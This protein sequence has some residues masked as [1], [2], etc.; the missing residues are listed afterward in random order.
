MDDDGTTDPNGTW[1][2]VA[3]EVAA[4]ARCSISSDVYS[5]A[6]TTFFA[7]SGEYPVSTKLEIVEQA[8]RI[9]SGKIRELRDLAPH[10]PQSVATVVRK[11]LSLSAVERHGS[12]EDFANALAAAMDGRRDWARVQHEGHTFCVHGQPFKNQ[13]NVV[14]CTEPVG[15]NVQLRA[16]HKTSNRRVKGCADAVVTHSRF[17]VELRGL[18]SGLS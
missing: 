13:A 12:A 15:T 8:E 10:V 5:L 4:G 18:V 2:T 3:P 14:I 7:L 1:Q 16:R 17:A 6:A 11:A 9:K